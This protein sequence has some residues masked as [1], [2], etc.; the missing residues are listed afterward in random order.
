ML[1]LR[2]VVV[3]TWKYIYDVFDLKRKTGCIQTPIFRVQTD[4]HLQSVHRYFELVFR[5]KGTYHIVFCIFILLNTQHT[6]KSQIILYMIKNTFW[7]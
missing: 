1:Y 3:L 6:E 4:L 2:P 7:I 5:N